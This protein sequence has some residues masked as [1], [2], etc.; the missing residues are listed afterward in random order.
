MVFTPLMCTAIDVIDDAQTYEFL[1]A[2]AQLHLNDW[3]LFYVSSVYR[4][5]SSSIQVCWLDE[6]SVCVFVQELDHNNL[7]AFL[8]SSIVMAAFFSCVCVCVA[9]EPE[10]SSV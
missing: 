3:I 2:V 8:S 4:I 10:K 1:L 6:R 5:F 7:M 9:F